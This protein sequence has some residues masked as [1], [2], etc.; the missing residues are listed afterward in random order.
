MKLRLAAHLVI[1][2]LFLSGAA[3]AFVVELEPA[4]PILVGQTSTFRVHNLEGATGAVTFQWILGDGTTIDTAERVVS[5]VYATA[6][7][8]SVNIVAREDGYPRDGDGLTHIVHHPL[9]AT[10]PHNSSSILVDEERRRVWNVNPDNDSITVIDADTLQRVGEVRVGD[11]PHYLA[12]APDGTIWVTN[13][14][15]DEVVVVDRDSAEVTARIPMPYASQPLGLVFGPSG[16][17]YV[18][19]F[20]TGNLVEIDPSS[21]QVRREV[22]L[23]PMPAGVSAAGD[24]RIFVTR[25]I[26]A[27]PP[28]GATPLDSYGEVWVVSPETFTLRTTIQLPFDRSKESNSSGPGVPN[29]V[30]SFVISPDGTQA[31]V[32]AKKD[33]VSHGPLLDHQRNS[34]ESFVRAITCVVD[35]GTET[36]IV[37][38][39]IDLDNRSM[40]VSVA[41]APLGNQAF[42]LVEA[43]NR[44]EF[45]DAFTRANPGA[46]NDVGHAPDGLALSRD[47]RLFV[48]AFLSRQVI[49]YDMQAALAT[50]SQAVSEPFVPTGTVEKEALSDT[51]LLGKQVFYDASDGRMSKDTYMSCVSCHFGGMSDG[52]AWDFSVRGEGIRNT[53]A[54]L[55][56]RGTGQGRVH[57]SANFDEIQDFERDIRESFEGTGFMPDGEFEAR[58]TAPDGGY[59]PFGK[60]AAGVSKE[61]DALAEYFATFD[62]A[63]RSPFRNPDGSFTREAR[64]G[65]R[66]FERAGCPT[67]H[68]PP[69]FTDSGQSG[70]LH[71]VGTLTSMSG[72]RLGR[73]LL[74]IDTPGLKGLWQSAPYLHDGR[75]PALSDIFR[76][77]K[78]RMGKTS[79]LSQVEV[80]ALVEYLKELDDVP[81]QPGVDD[82]EVEGGGRLDCSF[83]RSRDRTPGIG[84]AWLLLG[85]AIAAS[86]RMR[87]TTKKD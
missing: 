51:V 7:N 8:Y 19:L 65:R 77:T 21:R 82:L 83:G 55:G 49:T 28:V 60:P 63:P 41:F 42:V 79:D 68:A 81:E 72:R 43:G 67:C 16:M 76:I 33:N 74:G 53:K 58:E 3:N 46:L 64:A 86:R 61:L 11:E 26:S 62:K 2:G 36:E 54:L 47:G 66:I 12:Q 1:A 27:P 48:N 32:T 87:S 17:A 4:P 20:A 24:G 78:D 73:P 40:P 69:D 9:T 71:D 84:F 80:G 50:A 85:A 34:F 25:F 57:W 52:R 5:H 56:G 15:S 39:R 37:E 59:D 13:Q 29:Y 14:M 31:W 44:I 23:G 30:S 6:G 10:P 70:S 75:A 35:M 18:A 38:K 45:Y 22:A